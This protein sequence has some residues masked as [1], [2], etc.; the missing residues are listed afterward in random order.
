MAKPHCA[1]DVV[2]L[3]PLL[4]LEGALRAIDETVR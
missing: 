2:P 3:R 1:Q 4:A